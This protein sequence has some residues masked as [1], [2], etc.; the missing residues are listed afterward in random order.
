MRELATKVYLDL[1]L[2]VNIDSD[3]YAIQTIWTL[4]NNEYDFIKYLTFYLLDNKTQQ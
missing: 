4:N 1:K 2:S 3:L